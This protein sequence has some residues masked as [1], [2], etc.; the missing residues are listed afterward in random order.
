MTKQTPTKLEM[1]LGYFIEH[2]GRGI[3]MEVP[4]ERD[5]KFHWSWSKPR[6]EAKLF[7]NY[8]SANKVFRS[9]PDNIRQQSCIREMRTP[10]RKVKGFGGD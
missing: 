7:G 9:L 4:G 8:I 6:T 5:E 10:Y 3:L 1:L 2:P